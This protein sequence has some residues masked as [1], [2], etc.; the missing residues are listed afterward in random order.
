MTKE[1][2]LSLTDEYSIFKAFYRPDIL[3]N[4]AYSSPF[5]QDDN[6]SFVLFEPS[7]SI[8]NNRVL[9]KDHST[10][11]VGDCFDFIKKMYNVN[12]NDALNIIY[13]R[14]Y[15]NEIIQK[16]TSIEKKDIDTKNTIIPEID[17]WGNGNYYFW[18]TFNI[19]KETLS[20]YNVYPIKKAYIKNIYMVHYKDDFPVYCYMFYDIGKY[21]KRGF[22]LY[23]PH[24]QKGKKFLRDYTYNVTEG[25]KQLS[26]NKTK[27]L[28]IITKSLKDVMILHQLGINSVSVPSESSFIN[29]LD[30][31]FI[32][33]KF[34]KLILLFDND[35]AGIQNSNKLCIKYNIE[36]IE[37]PREY[38]IKDISDFSKETSLDDCL[39]L[40]KK[41]CPYL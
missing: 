22:K 41:L 37:I 5:R 36:K 3:L 33:S 16:P 14:F 27:D 4:K 21:S 8:R 17:S 25:F 12:Y 2:I 34:K 39:T 30:Y 38:K 24:N 7:R 1:E 10:G 23:F 20:L 13:K 9:Y 29:I 26:S 28:C 35:N 18:N 31:N 19:T 40:L 15:N 6:P 11:E 32:R